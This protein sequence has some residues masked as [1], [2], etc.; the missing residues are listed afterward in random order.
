MKLPPFSPAL[1]QALAVIAVD[2]EIDAEDVIEAALD[3]RLSFGVNGLPCADKTVVR[4]IRELL[5]APS[6]DQAA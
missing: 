3:V 2:F 5:E 4:I 6:K 1:V